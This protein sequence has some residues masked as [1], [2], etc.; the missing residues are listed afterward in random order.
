MATNQ[1]NQ[2]NQ[3]GSSDQGS[4]ESE[5]GFASMSDEEQRRIAQKG[6]EASAR[7]QERDENGQFTGSGSSGGDRSS[8]SQGSRGGS[9]GSGG[10]SRSRA[11]A[12]ADPGPGGCPSLASARPVST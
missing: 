10:G 12:L 2:G 1:G 7:Q 4:R 9:Q 8:G 6:G 11:A 3:G 5:R